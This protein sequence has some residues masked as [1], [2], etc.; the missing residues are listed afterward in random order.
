MGSWT[1]CAL[2]QRATSPL[3]HVGSVAPITP[4]SSVGP[5][6]TSRSSSA[7]LEVGSPQLSVSRPIVANQP[8]AEPRATARC[9]TSDSRTADRSMVTRANVQRKGRARSARSTTAPTSSW[10]GVTARSTTNASR[11]MAMRFIS[12][13]PSEE[14][15]T[16]TATGTG[17]SASERR[18]SSSTALS[19]S[20]AWDG[21]YSL[22]RRCI[23]RMATGSTTAS[24][25]WS[26]GS[27]TI[28]A[29]R[30]RRIARLAPVSRTGRDWL[31][32]A[33]VT[34]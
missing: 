27:A 7:D 24:T 33:G 6:S 22:T 32:P 3:K 19:W 20:K 12:K 28:R 25:I 2:Q 17:G 34:G 14:Q 5:M 26:S 29:E 4:V 21:L 8:M 30:L 10:V 18:T 9:T 13:S 16:L 11:D 31:S 23:T 15:A 1:T